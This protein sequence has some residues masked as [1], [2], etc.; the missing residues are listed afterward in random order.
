MRYLSYQDRLVIEKLIGKD[1]VVEIANRLGFH[2]TTIY[3]E[4]KR[5]FP[6][7]YSARAGEKKAR[8]NLAARK[9]RGKAYWL[10]LMRGG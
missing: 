6:C 10:K 4:V 1:S 5:Q 8:E 3:R 7:E 9:R 2:P